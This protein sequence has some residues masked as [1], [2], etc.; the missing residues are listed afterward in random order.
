MIIGTEMETN[1]EYQL[2]KFNALEKDIDNLNNRITILT[3]GKGSGNWGHKGRPGQIGGSDGGSGAG[4]NG[5]GG[6]RLKTKITIQKAAS[7][8][9]KNGYI[10][11][12]GKTDLNTMKTSYDVTTPDGKRKI[13]T[14]KEIETL[15]L[16][17]K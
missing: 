7:L 11:G 12:K 14:A 2:E 16:G 8:L 1:H 5:E 3:K 17:L 15:A 4:G 10:L 9:A 13:M 6:K